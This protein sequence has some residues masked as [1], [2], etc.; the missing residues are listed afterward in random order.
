MEPLL[1]F[2][3]D[4]AYKKTSWEEFQKSFIGKVK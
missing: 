4:K 1:S 2:F 3:A